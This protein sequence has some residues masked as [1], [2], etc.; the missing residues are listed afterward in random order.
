MY[1]EA[2]LSAKDA[3]A[4]QFTQSVKAIDFTKGVSIT[5]NKRPAKVI[6]AE[7]DDEQ[8]DTVRY[9]VDNPIEAGASI[10]WSYDC[11]EGFIQ[12]SSGDYLRSIDPKPV[13]ASHLTKRTV[14]PRY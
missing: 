9:T 6:R 11:L 12:N 1:V 10:E 8:A 5:V 14:F 3:I 13:S 4:V 7:R 2:Q